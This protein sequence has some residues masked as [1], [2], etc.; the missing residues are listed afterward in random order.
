MS[1]RSSR[2]G[3][4][5]AATISSSKSCSARP[6]CFDMLA[7]DSIAASVRT[8]PGQTALTRMPRG[9]SSCAML[10]MKPRFACLLAT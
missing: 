4:T 2:P 10:R 3:S 8:Q 7:S 1:S 9:P 5:C 6:D